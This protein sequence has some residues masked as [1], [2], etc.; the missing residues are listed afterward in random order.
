MNIGTHTGL[1]MALPY[2]ARMHGFQLNPPDT[3]G[4]PEGPHDARIVSR[5]QLAAARTGFDVVD[6]AAARGLYLLLPRPSLRTSIFDR[7][8]VPSVESDA[9]FFPLWRGDTLAVRGDVLL[10]VR[11]LLRSEVDLLDLA[12]VAV[13]ERDG[14]T[15]HHRHI[16]LP[17][18]RRTWR[19]EEMHLLIRLPWLPDADYRSVHLHNPRRETVDIGRAEVKAHR[20]IT[21]LPH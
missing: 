1:G 9:E 2:A 3:Y 7:Y 10:Q 11:C 8:T 15:I 16:G 18:L 5:E 17:L 12:L 20:I 6:S 4:F 13:A 19:G 14:V 21:V